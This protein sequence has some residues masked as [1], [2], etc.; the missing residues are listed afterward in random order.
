MRVLITRSR[1]PSSRASHTSRDDRK[2]VAVAHVLLGDTKEPT[3]SL[4]HGRWKMAI[5]DT[6]P[7]TVIVRIFLSNNSQ[8]TANLADAELHF[9][10]GSLAGLKLLGF[11]IWDHHG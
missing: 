8:P 3:T 7:D 1:P 2:S 5:I 10:G 9:V 6:A 11:A 4:C